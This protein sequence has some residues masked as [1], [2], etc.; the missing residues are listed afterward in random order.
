MTT[1]LHQ[2]LDWF[3]ILSRLFA[4]HLTEEWR[5][6]AYR[7]YQE[8]ENEQPVLK[9][10][11]RIT[12]QLRHPERKHLF[13]VTF[14]DFAADNP[15]NRILRFVVERL[16]KT[17]RDTETYRLLDRLRQWMDEVRL[18]P[19][20]PVVDAKAFPITRMNQ[21]YAPLLELA[22]LFLDGS[23]L[24]LS[25]GNRASFAFT[26]DMNQLFERFLVNFIHRH[27]RELLPPELCDCDLLPQSQGTPR[28]LA[29]RESHT[30]VFRLK[31]DLVFRKKAM[32]TFPLILD[33]KYKRLEGTEGTSGVS[34]EDFYQ[35]YAY[36]HRF[37]SPYVL[38]LYPQTAELI[39]PLY[40]RFALTGYESEIIAATVDLRG[41]LSS[42]AYQR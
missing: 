6:G 19:T 21:R 34:R 16:W 26:L 37:R 12:E 14:D 25:E 39:V 17:T 8:T 24:H 11:W 9:G 22:C 15:L 10:R 29:S 1:L 27:R 33:A 28:Y 20:V 13:A 31:P 41:D 32:H 38:L 36:A 30:P 4:T 42:K 7:S 3:E 2:H 40:T 18:L 35:M 5:H 23:G